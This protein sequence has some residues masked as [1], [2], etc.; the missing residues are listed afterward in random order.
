ME[1]EKRSVSPSPSIPPISREQ[2]LL[3]T[4]FHALSQFAFDKA[5]DQVEKEKETKRLPLVYSTPWSSL[6]VTLSHLA[7]AEKTYFS[8]PFIAKKFFRKDSVRDSFK[9][10]IT[11]LKRIEETTHSSSSST[12]SP[13]EGS[14]EAMAIMGSSSNVNYS[15]LS[16]MIDEICRRHN[17]GFHHPILDSLKSSFSFEVDILCNLLKA[18][19]DMADWKFLSSLLHLHESHVKL[20]SWCQFLPS[21]E[22]SA[23]LTLKKSLFGSTPKK[24]LE[25]PFLYQWLGKLQD[26]L[27]SKFTL[28]FYH[29]LGRQTTPVDMKSLTARASIDYIGRITAFIRRSDAFNVCMLL[30]THQLEPYQGHGYHLPHDVKEKPSGLGAFPA[31]FSFPGDRPVDHWPNIVSILLDKVQELN[32]MEK[33]VFFFDSGVQSTYFLTRVDPRMTLVVI[34]NSKRSEKDSYVTTFLTE[35]ATLLRNTKIFAMLKQGGRVKKTK[36]PTAPVTQAVTPTVS[37]VI[38][39][40]ERSHDNNLE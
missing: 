28:Y 24:H 21:V 7:L 32:S 38:T 37:M 3:E 16:N 31:V 35:T 9:T 15:D 30:D 19:C 14:Y 20:S 23:S 17:K 26:A 27:V 11:E 40:N 5:K 39:E 25:A 2:A 36:L 34:F 33:I 6:L 4:F 1:S 13:L 18:Q 10:L 22:L 29:I 12:G 8:L